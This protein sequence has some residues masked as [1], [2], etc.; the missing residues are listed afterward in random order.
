MSK[1]QKEYLNMDVYTAAKKRIKHIIEIFDS[2]IIAFSGGKDSLTVLSLVEEVYSELGIKEK[3]KVFFRDEELI[4]DDV[5]N[6]VI[7]KYNTGKYDFKYYAI[8]LKSTKFILGKTVEYIQ[9]DKS[10]KWLREPPE[11]AIKSGKVFDQYSADGFICKDLSGK[12]AILTGIRA[13]ES[14]VRLMSCVNKK[15]ENYIN[16]TDYKN[17]KICKPIYDWSEDD[18]F[19]YFYKNNIKYCPI[20]D[21]QMLNSQQL[22]VATPLHQ[23]NAKR[24]GKLKTLYPIFYEQLMDLFPEMK[25]Q[26]KYWEEYNKDSIYYKYPHSID[27]VIQYINENI[28]D[29]S[30]RE[31]AVLRVHQAETIRNSHL[32]SENYGGYPI[33]HIFKNIVSGNYKRKIMPKSKLSREE[34][35]YESY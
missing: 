2:V 30:Q 6:F 5:I 32:N 18:V 15:N 28:E 27:G 23:E 7:D 13:D 8:P 31:L 29:K 26:E 3:I 34:K 12:V 19:L 1:Q 24:I 17:I 4:P 33:L 11:F 21:L 10:R 9:W 25:I 16:A 22:R 14:L 35:E 20:Y